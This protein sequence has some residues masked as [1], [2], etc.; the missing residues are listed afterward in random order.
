MPTCTGVIAEYNPFHNG[1]R[2]QLSEARRVTGCE[3]VAVVMSGSFVQRGEVAMFDKFSRARWALENGADIVFLLPTVYSC[4]R[5]DRFAEGAVRILGGTGLVDALC[6]GSESGDASKIIRMAALMA[7]ESDEQKACLRAHLKQGVS[8]PNAR[9]KMLNER[10]GAHLSA[11]ASLPNDILGIEYVRAIARFAP[12]LLPFAIKRVGAM[13]DANRTEGSVA[14]ASA[15]RKAVLENDRNALSAC[16]P[17]SVAE[18]I[19]KQLEDGRAPYV[20]ERFSDAVLY[21]L[22][23]MPREALSRLPDVSEGLENVLYRCAREASCYE[24]LLSLLKTKRYTLARLKRILC[25]A[26]LGVEERLYADALPYIRVLG[27]RKSALPMLS[28]LASHA[29]LPVVTRYA[30][31]AALPESARRLHE[32]DLLAAELAPLA[33]KAPARAAFDY[34]EPLILV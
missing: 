5:A 24:E 17:Q 16:A 15:L 27:V 25:Y 23:R 32:I 18:D 31:A 9:T 2:Y 19:I 10:H 8:F 26:L 30:D 1:H 33:L 4:A 11:A 3:H 21:A 34:G 6:F 20:Q 22:R 7:E 12:Q 28:S 13:H 14:S 29:T